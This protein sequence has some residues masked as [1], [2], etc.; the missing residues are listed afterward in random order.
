[1][2]LYMK[3]SLFLLLLFLPFL[4]FA[5]A[6]PPFNYDL[7]L[8]SIPGKDQRTMICFHGY[9]HNYQI[10]DTLKNLYHLDTTLIS[11]NF[12]D[13]KKALYG[14]M[15]ELLPALYVIKKIVLDNHLPSVDFYGFSAGGGAIVN[16]LAILNTTTFDTELKKVGIGP[17]EKKKL[18]E[19]IQKGIVILDAPLKS[20]EEIIDFR[21]S[22]EDLEFIAKQYRENNLRPID[23]LNLLKGLC[24]NVIL[25]FDKNDEIISNRDDQLYSE[26]LK[27]SQSCG[28][29]T[30]II[31]DEGGHMTPHYALWK[32]YKGYIQ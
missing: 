29:V 27:N 17:E 23:S 2:M 22:S 13:T 12:P 5:D 25:Y 8:Y 30:V 1:M 32:A 18:L 3:K 6:E 4:S 11:F 7:H 28:K 14:T 15:D 24:L 26:R 19:V 9:G 20:M 10:A 16:I 21:G 31:E